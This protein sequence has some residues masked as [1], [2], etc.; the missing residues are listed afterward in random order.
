[1]LCNHP[2]SNIPEWL[3]DK[4]GINFICRKCYEHGL[5]RPTKVTKLTEKALALEKAN[6][7]Q[8]K[9]DKALMSVVDRLSTQH[10]KDEEEFYNRFS[11]SD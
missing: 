8:I 6:E 3:Q 9:K 4:E 1:M 11:K 2:K 10:T 7:A 5:N